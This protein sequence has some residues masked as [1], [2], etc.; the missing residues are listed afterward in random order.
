MTDD[1]RAHLQHGELIGARYALVSPNRAPTGLVGM[2]LSRRIG[3]SLEFMDHREYQ[4][5]DDPRRI[6]WAAYARTDRLI[7]KL[8]REEVSPHLDLIID[9]SRSMAV[10][11]TAKAEAT[12]TLA[13]ALASAAR[14]SS[15]THAA[16]LAGAPEGGFRRVANSTDSPAAWSG[17]T[18][19][20]F[21]QD[22]ESFAAV[23]PGFRHQGVRVF[24][25]DLLWRGD[26][27][28]LLPRLAHGAAA[29]AVIQLV[30]ETDLEPPELGNVRLIDSE[31]AAIREVFVDAAAADRYRDNVARHQGR[32]SRACQH[33]GA[34]MT[35]LVAE[36]LVE[37][38]DLADLVLSNLLKVA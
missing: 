35:T 34:T 6:D 33:V 36:R 26:P 24:M 16:Y 15:F 4:P 1:T 10:E 37:R 5:G 9:G 28:V 25:S 18:F 19:D 3:T 32:W 20:F 29:L 11:G 21:G 7:V 27:M 12:V 31:T 30:A 8:H 22:T 14:N 13:A 23:N 2:Q 17:L 38:F